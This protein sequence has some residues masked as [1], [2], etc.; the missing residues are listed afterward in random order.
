V[1][2]LHQ[3]TLVLEDVTLGLHVQNVVPI[4]GGFIVKMKREDMLALM[5]LCNGNVCFHRKSHAICLI[6]QKRRKRTY[7]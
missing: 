7:K 6:K 5:T 3:D 4:R 1:D 2:V